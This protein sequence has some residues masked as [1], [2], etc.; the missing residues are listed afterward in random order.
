MQINILFF[1]E[2]LNSKHLKRKEDRKDKPLHFS[3]FS[4]MFLLPLE[5]GAHTSFCTKP[6]RAKGRQEDKDLG[7]GQEMGPACLRSL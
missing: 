1:L 5:C 6:W 2:T 4:H 3:T 7:G